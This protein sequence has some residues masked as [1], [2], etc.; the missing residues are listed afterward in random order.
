MEVEV[1][2]LMVILLTV[3]TLLWSAVVCCGLAYS[4]VSVSDLR[5]LH[6]ANN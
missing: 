4:V 5:L 3:V 6:T 2:S 1:G